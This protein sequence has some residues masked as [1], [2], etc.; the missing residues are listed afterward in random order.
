MNLSYIA[1]VGPG[2]LFFIDGIAKEITDVVIVVSLG[3]ISVLGLITNIINMIVLLKPSYKDGMRIELFSLA[4]TDF[5]VSI[6]VF[7]FTVLYLAS[8][9]CVRSPVDLWALAYVPFV[10]AVNALYLISCWITAMISLERCFSVVFPFAVRQIFTARRSIILI[11]I[12]YAFHIALFLPAFIIDKM[13][14]VP[15]DEDN[16]GNFSSLSESPKWIY[17]VVFSEAAVELD[18]VLDITAGLFL[19]IYLYM[20]AQKG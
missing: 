13:E 5:F 14:W 6:L 20:A 19:F 7:A 8:I 10:W 12:I 3:F 11:V 1:F 2:E 4:I 17:T 9:F 18:V 15:L 16:I